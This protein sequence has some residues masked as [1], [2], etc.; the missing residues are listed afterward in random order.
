LGTDHVDAITEISEE[1][2][3]RKMPEMVEIY[4]QMEADVASFRPS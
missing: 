1:E 2:Y 3:Q 4:E